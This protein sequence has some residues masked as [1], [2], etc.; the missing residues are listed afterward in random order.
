MLVS[1]ELYNLSLHRG[2]LS[3]LLAIGWRIGD[4]LRDF[5][6]SL[7]EVRMAAAE[8]SDA[9]LALSLLGRRDNRPA[10]ITIPDTPRP[11]DFLFYHPG[12]GTRLNFT[13][14]RRHSSLPRWIQAMEWLVAE[15]HPSA[16]ATYQADLDRLVQAVI[17]EPMDLFCRIRQVRCRPL[18]TGDG[19]AVKVR[20]HRCGCPCPTTL[21]WDIE[22]EICCR[23]C[24]GL[25]P[26]WLGTE[27]ILPAEADTVINSKRTQRKK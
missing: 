23:D 14:I 25:E 22:G 10:R 13:L 17:S 15:G 12:T 16:M 26:S 1:I 6:N 27:A 5:F 18:L 24:C 19:P 4:Y 2:Y 11:W 7:D 9:V 20:C 8:E 3:P 21:A